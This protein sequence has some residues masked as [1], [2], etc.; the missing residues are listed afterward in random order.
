MISIVNSIARS[1]LAAVF[2]WGGIDTLRNPKPRVKAA[3]SLFEKT[4]KFGATISDANQ[5]NL[6]TLN[7]AVM[8]SAGALLVLGKT[9]RLA[10]LALAGSMVPTTLAGHAYWEH[11]DPRTRSAHKV[12]L[13]KNASALGGMVLYASRSGKS[14]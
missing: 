13:L 10:S 1:M 4:A 3:K 14:R 7:A 11:D 2:I 5:E 6:V 12:Q 8:V 9:P